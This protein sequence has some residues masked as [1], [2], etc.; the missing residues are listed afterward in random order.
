MNDEPDLLTQPGGVQVQWMITM[1]LWLVG[2]QMDAGKQHAHTER[3]QVNLGMAEGRVVGRPMFIV[4]RDLNFGK[5]GRE[6]G[7]AEFGRRS[8][9]RLDTMDNMI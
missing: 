2:G 9:L 8:R 5:G 4:C 3:E 1:V 6:G 7:R